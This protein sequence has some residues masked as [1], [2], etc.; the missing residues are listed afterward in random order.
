MN[1]FLRSTF[2][3]RISKLGLGLTVTLLVLASNL[4]AQSYTK[5]YIAPAPWNY[6]TKANEL[7]VTT[8]SVTPVT[9]T[10]KKSDGTSAFTLTTKAGTPAV[11]RFTGVITDFPLHPLNSV[12]SGAGIIV[13]ASTSINVNI[14]NIAS[15][16]NDVPT[17]YFIKGNSSLFSFGDAAVGNAFRVGYYRDGDIYKN[18]YS[19][20]DGPLKPVYSV[21][22]TENNTVVS[23]NG[24]ATVTL[25]AGQSYLFQAKMGSLVETSGPAVMNT[26]AT[27]DAPVVV[28][29]CYD[30][31]S[32]PV[33]P[34]N[35]L[36][37]EYIVVRGNGNNIA[38]KTTVIA[39]E[40]NTTVTIQNFTPAG[41]LQSSETFNLIAAGSFKTFANGIPEFAADANGPQGQ[42][43]S[44][45]RIIA[46]KNVV[47]Y[48]GT[49]QD[50]EVDV[51]T[52]APISSCSGSNRT[53]TVKFTKL[54]SGDLPYFSYILLQSATSKVYLTTDNG[55]TNKDIET[56]AGV[57]IRRQ[58]GSSG[59]YII[60]FDNTNIN[61]PRFITL[62]SD[63]RLTVN[64]VQQGGGFSM[65]NFI[66]AFP[67]KA[68]KPTVAQSNCAT[69]TLN[70]SPNSSAP[71]QWYL[72]G[73]A[74]SGATNSSFEALKS[75]TY[76]LTTKL[77]CGISAQSLPVTVALCNVDISINKTV[78]NL[79]PAKG[80]T[81]VFS[82]TANNSNVAS[83]SVTGTGNAIGISATD[84]LPSGYTFVSSEAPTGT[85]YDKTTGIWSIGAMTSGET[86][87]LKITA[88][89]KSSGNYENTATIAGPQ[90]D[91]NQDNNTSTVTVTPVNISLTSAVGTNAQ[92]VCSGGAIATTTYQFIGSGSVTNQS[93]ENLPAGI[94]PVFTSGDKT[95]KLT[96]TPPINNS[97]SPIVYTY[98]V[99]GTISG[100]ALEA[101]GTITVNP[102]VATPVFAK[103]ENS[104]RCQGFSVE[105]YTA[106]TSGVTAI[107]YSISPANA[108]VINASTGEVT[109]SSIYEGIATITASTTGCN[110]TKSA[111][112]TVAITTSGT[113]EGAITVC[114]G[115]N[116]FVELKNTTAAVVRWESST[117][118]GASWSTINSTNK[119]LNYTDLNVT[120][121]YRAVVTGNGC[122]E[123]I[124]TSAKIT[125]IPRPVVADQVFEIC[126]AGNFV[127]KPTY[128]PNGTTYT[129]ATPVINGS[130]NGQ[131]SGNNAT[132]I[133]QTLTNTSSTLATATYTVTPRY[134]TCDG[135]PFKI[136]VN[137]APT[138][139]A[140]IPNPV[141]ICSGNA[142]TVTPVSNLTGTTYRWTTSLR[143]GSATGFGAETTPSNII[144]QTITN[145]GSTDAVVEYNVTPVNGGCTGS[146]FKFTVTVAPAIANN[147]IT[148]S[149]TICAGRKP[150]QLLG[151]SPT[152][153]NNSFTYEWE[154]STD[155]INW[156]VA[157][158]TKDGIN[159]A[160]NTLTQTTQYRR[161]V[162]S[163]N[164]AVST[165]TPV[166]ITVNQ[167]PVVSPILNQGNLCVGESRQLNNATPD[168]IWSSSAPAFVTVST[169]GLITA[170]AIGNATI[171]YTTKANSSGCTNSVSVNIAVSALP[172]VSPITNTGDVCIG[173]TRQLSNATTGGIWSSS[174]PAIATISNN[175]L[176]TALTT[177]STVISYKT[178]TNNNGCA[179][180]TSYT[181]IV[182]ATPQG[183]NDVVNTLTCSNST[184]NYN[185]QN[186]VNNLE[187]GGNGVAADFSWTISNNTNVLGASASNGKNI[188]QTLI[189]TSNVAQQVVYTVTPKSTLAGACDG[190]V[191]TVTVNV[192]VCSSVTVAKN[193][194][195]TSVNKAGDVINYTIVVK[196]TGNA[197]QNAV[198]V[199]DPFVT[200][201]AAVKT[202]G[203]NDAILDKDEI[204][205]YNG[206]YT[207]KQADLDN[208]GKPALN[209][210]F[211]Q[212]V[213]TFSSTEITAQTASN[214]IAIVTEGKLQLVKT[215][216]L[217]ANGDEITYSFLIRNTGNV[218]INNLTLSDNK[219]TGAISLA[220]ITLV[221]GEST[222]AN[223]TYQIT[224]AEK[225]IGT[226]TNTATV[227]GKNPQG[228][229]V[230]AISGF[231]TT[232][233]NPTVI[234][235]GVYPLNDEGTVNAV[236]GG[237]G[238]E[239]VL[240]NDK[241]N[242]NQATLTNVKIV[243]VSSTHANI[244]LNANGEVVVLPNTP[245]G[246]YSLV[247]EIEDKANSNNKKTAVVTVNV[248]SGVIKANNDNGTANAII[249]GIAVADILANDTFNNGSK[250]TLATVTITE[251]S[252]TSNGAV[253]LN[254]DGSVAVLAGTK[255]GV[256]TI[257]YQIVDK[258]DASKKSTAKVEVV[259]A[260]GNIVANNDNGTA[261]AITGGIAVADILA[262]D[263]FNNGSQATLATVTITEVSNNSN[264]AVKLNAD[265]SVAVLA[266]TKAGL[267]TIEYQIADKLDAGKIST[268]K[269]EVVVASGNIVAKNDNGTA[270]GFAGG[271]TVENILTN[272]TYNNGAKATLSN[273]AIVQVSTTNGNIN[274]DP[275]TGKV[276]VLAGTISGTY[277]IVYQITDKQ[278][279]SKTSSA[280]V[281][282]VIP[283]WV[284]DLAVT[285]TANKTAVE[286]NEAISYTITVINN[287][288]ATILANQVIGLTES[289]PQGLT[290][291]TY[292]TNGGVYSPSNNT[293]TPSAA[294]NVG[295]AV[296]LIVNGK[297]EAN[298][299]QANLIN[300]VVANASTENTD[301]NNA[302]N[303]AS[304]ATAVV[305]GKMT[306]VKTGILST[307]GNSIT[308][309]F[310]INNIGS[311]VLNNINL[312]DTK[313]NLN[314]IIAGP[315]APGATLT[316]TEVYV[317]TQSDKDAGTVSNTATATAKTP[318]GNTIT[319]NSG[320]GVNNT[321]PTVTVLPGKPGLSFTKIASG[322]VP[323]IV[324][325][326][327][328]YNLVVTNTGNV[329]LNN[330]VVTDNNATITNGIIATLAPSQSVTV[331]ASH[332]L[333]QSDVNAG[334]VINQA[335]VSA[336]DK[337][338]KAITKVSDDP[339]TTVADD[340]T[341]TVIA[342]VATVKFTKTVN[343][344]GAKRGDVLNYTLLA[345]NTGTVT[346]YDVY[347]VDETADAGSVMPVKVDFI[348]PG[349][350][351]VFMAKRTITQADINL[352][353]FSNQAIFYG[354]DPQGRIVRQVSDDPRTL[355]ADDPTITFFT[356]T[357]DL[358]TVK[359]LKNS[360]QKTYTPGDEVLYLINIKNNGPS[361]AR[362]VKIV[363]HAPA[364]T[365][366]TR[367]KAT[368][369]G[370]VLPAT[371]GTGDLEQLIPMFPGE[372]EVEYEVTVK[373]ADG[374]TNPVAAGKPLSNT[375]AVTSTTLD[376]TN[377]GDILTT[378]PINA[379][380]ANDLSIV[381]TSDHLT[382][383]GIDMP[384]DYTI[385]VK[386][387]GSFPAKAV[388]VSDV[389]PTNL[390]YISH[391]IVNGT[392]N[393]DLGKNTFTWNVESIPAGGTVTLKLTVKAKTAGVVTNTAT[394]SA[395]EIDSDL[396]NNSST[397]TKQIFALNTKPNVITPNGDGKN[398]AF[399]ID[400]LELYPENTLNI[401]NRWGNEVYRSTG[402]YKNNWDGHNLQEGTYYY[403]LKI[404]DSKGVWSA[405]K[406]FITLLR[407]N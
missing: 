370:L 352:G 136:T 312:V 229:N 156:T 328:N 4:K 307:D 400:G 395:A 385:T 241:I 26:S 378:P 351:A 39:T 364:G 263:T 34:V 43:Y 53:E 78:N 32:N 163:N 260:S 303:S 407:N 190:K 208:N 393:F 83:G 341:V 319:A 20:P 172:S 102:A 232:N 373:T 315:I 270:N 50:C 334:K 209:S 117:D 220:K 259:V 338:G 199:T 196:N 350:T 269:V 242:G 184:F 72:D 298:Y 314:K 164:C 56:I 146:D 201:G 31:T 111:T 81:V 37:S 344:T 58:L 392:G 140:S 226:V 361:T 287:G 354:K 147:T 283:N 131:S 165:S 309:T 258:L 8:A 347:I 311:V 188:T 9:V 99:K 255:A 299:S 369:K 47:A 383:T 57:G 193:A 73:V 54:P 170:V 100:T 245:V 68:I 204:W 19:Y 153:G 215:G 186:N 52:L 396:A 71:Y 133:N 95:Y 86:K 244:N 87:I 149:Q 202:N 130:V 181:L 249:G 194:D 88:T 292:Q 38:E 67:E 345:K 300:S 398:D 324:G 62:T 397:D 40:P 387:T 167:L 12:I 217:S 15:D 388:A 379:I 60:D 276:N 382:P 61:S 33:P 114:S 273:V 343:N 404:K 22:A 101:I 119:K 35:S 168:G 291:V 108:G 331:L 322:T 154:Q 189:N 225:L 80:S 389:L 79:S 264:G 265:G 339:S 187:L 234:K 323:S 214:T 171:T 63:A 228:A 16:D 77:D 6:F 219:I 151:S 235:T 224:T 367:W 335:N 148:A 120:T 301:P 277:T 84:I 399:V 337:D 21:M 17:S 405:T 112:H 275:L 192:P 109:W 305:T 222:T 7:V 271:V 134:Q 103:G 169:E 286:P 317:L 142:F 360:A 198:S 295:E 304:V 390:T 289:L 152:G 49:A 227:K 213:A 371:S 144:S 2:L 135:K 236:T 239:N 158:G 401:F 353:F 340:A 91:P 126:K 159:Y 113:V 28:E 386:N 250:A 5:H 96:G 23:I 302:N 74:I 3:S 36:G 128:V 25:S 157:N 330:I 262:N 362:D 293:F 210:A 333:T 320:N 162:K 51:A 178:A 197:K 48:S 203:N 211:I 41:V 243:Q 332:I 274:I 177:G 98:K 185:L 105:T 27:Y 69:A 107:T 124:S 85:S 267:Y 90:V 46:S 212:N 221:P 205:T 94:T 366:I 207:V 318:A 76:T 247:Y 155:G 285:K 280:S 246:V 313:L 121:I 145:S 321:D 368:A 24:V 116:G 166:I 348:L 92:T 160:P 45:T 137:I 346:L 272:D 231:A 125:L 176:V 342:Q 11:H 297:V 143:S 251:L 14:R 29:S 10:V 150:N 118:E 75:G 310:A 375:V 356:P 106:S 308:Y 278:D 42:R 141:S 394:V 82:L 180:S 380:I 1:L 115:A 282:V 288:P 402:S 406:G 110:G 89:V 174:N 93:V 326:I 123:A 374:R 139:T 55:Y 257:E 325:A 391:N 384:F 240:I 13:E 104:A 64:M 377:E 173:S 218:T 30:G 191:F 357:A 195:V 175:G 138:L 358:V 254:A 329:T 65:S 200:L 179:N 127:F 306:L 206:S 216:V 233:T 268:A 129:W 294:V 365:T 381:K 230:T 336:K 349:A 252:N 248:I 284:T 403:I 183:F 18:S 290:N 59:T 122:V 70:A 266:G 44:S 66:S 316:T 363:D 223:A 281:T 182:N 253:K 296:T 237:I 279:A 97:A 376:L 256:Y 132:E 238:V 355:L 161:N 372:G 327:I 261:N 359:K